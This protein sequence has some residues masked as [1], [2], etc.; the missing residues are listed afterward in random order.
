MPWLVAYQL[1]NG[2]M[3]VICDF[4]K[5]SVGRGSPIFPI[6]NI[7]LFESHFNGSGAWANIISHTKA[8]EIVIKRQ[9]KYLIFGQITKGSKSSNYALTMLTFCTNIGVWGTKS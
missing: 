4:N 3:E 9:N 5:R 2:Y 7:G 8:N 1:V 6:S